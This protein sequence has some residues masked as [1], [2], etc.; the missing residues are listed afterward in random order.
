MTPTSI[1]IFVFVFKIDECL[2][3]G[4]LGTILH[5][6]RAKVGSRTG[7]LLFSVWVVGAVLWVVCCGLCAV[8]TVCQ[9]EVKNPTESQNPLEVNPKQMKMCSRSVPG[10]FW[11]TSCVQVGPV[12]A[13]AIRETGFSGACLHEKVAQKMPF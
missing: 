5:S 8:F 4:R 13:R 11:V 1:Y 10:P 7:V 3:S 12:T 6:D 9:N 2:V